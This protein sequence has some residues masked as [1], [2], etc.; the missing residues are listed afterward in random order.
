MAAPTGWQGSFPCAGVELASN[1]FCVGCSAR[2]AAAPIPQPHPRKAQETPSYNAINF[3][4]T[5]KYNLSKPLSLRS[6]PLC[7]WNS[8]GG[9]REQFQSSGCCIPP[10]CPAKPLGRTGLTAPAS[11]TRALRSPTSS[12][13]AASS[14]LLPA[15][16][17]FEI[18]SHR[19]QRGRATP[20]A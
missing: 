14:Q 3:K 6:F 7:T 8:R 2:A 11:P 15:F 4:N 16:G 10:V 18:Q 20:G 9:R 1:G 5:Q 13:G 12:A 17:R 19:I